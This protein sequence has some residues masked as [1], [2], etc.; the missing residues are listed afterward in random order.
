MY[1]SVIIHVDDTFINTYDAWHLIPSSRPVISPPIERTK[2]VT[3]GGRSG[4]LD[5][6][7]SLTHKPVYDN[8]TGKIEFYVENDW[9]DS[10]ETAYTTITEA[11]QGKRVELALEDNPTHYYKGLLWVNGWKSQK[12]NSVITLEYNLH[13]TME[14]RPVQQLVLNR[15]AVT[16]Q[17]GMSFTL[18]VGVVPANTFHRKMTVDA[19][20]SNI[21]SISEDGRITAKKNG[22]CV[23][24]VQLGDKIAKCD[25]K[26]Q[27]YGFC[28]VT[29]SLTNC[30]NENQD[31]AVM[32]E[33]TYVAEIVP[34]AE[35]DISTVSVS[36]SG[37]DISETAVTIAE[38]KQSAS[39]RVEHVTGP[40]TITADAV[41]GAW[42]DVTYELTNV[43]LDQAPKRARQD[44]IL[45]FHA[46]AASGMSIYTA[47]VTVDGKDISV[48]GTSYEDLSNLKAEL[49]VQGPVVIKIEAKES[50]TLNDFSWKAIDWISQNGQAATMFKPGDTKTIHVEGRI[51]GVNY[52]AD[53]ET[54]ILGIN[55]NTSVEK[56]PAIHFGCGRVN[57]KWASLGVHQ[58]VTGSEV[59]WEL[60]YIRNTV[61]GGAGTPQDPVP[62]SVM[63]ALPE[64]LRG[65]MRSCVKSTYNAFGV[66]PTTDYLWLLSEFELFG[67][68]KNAD[69]N[70]QDT[71][72]QYAFFKTGDKHCGNVT[73]LSTNIFHWT[74]SRYPSINN[75][76]CCVNADGGSSNKSGT[77]R[78]GMIVCFGV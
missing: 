2:F 42:Y 69:K 9:W 56:G 61:L 46:T 4:S 38:D 62:N 24:R 47:V 31:E 66:N 55:H 11:L 22:A 20:P 48:E 29:N 63:A 52:N 28:R 59:G 76:Y 53:L 5:Y 39:I 77:N 8:R 33:S 64:D 17:R 37:V 10:W 45:R 36:M 50:P 72:K 6:S 23:I 34:N 74:R 65:V 54:V 73:A 43:T 30:Q 57:G 25:V 71:Q 14:S 3:V 21:V 26:V 58:F 12:G 78:Y 19:I 44:D 15:T 27:N 7:Q 16:L 13:P 67:R 68:I 1:H 51:M 40:I 70:E 60:S 32:E 41:P 35:H 75:W 49:T 18:L